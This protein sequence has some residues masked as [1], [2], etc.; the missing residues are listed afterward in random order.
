M[1]RPTNGGRKKDE[2]GRSDEN[3]D[4]C[5]IRGSAERGNGEIGRSAWIGKSEGHDGSTINVVY[6]KY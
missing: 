1:C 6:R 2:K 4:V 3:R 5:K